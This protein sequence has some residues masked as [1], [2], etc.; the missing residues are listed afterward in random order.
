[1]ILQLKNLT[2]QTKQLHLYEFQPEEVLLI[3]ESWYVEAVILAILSY[4]FQLYTDGQ[5]LHGL[6]Q[7]EA[8]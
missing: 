1:M 3:D 4:E 2:N 8:L 6:A 7:I 5:A